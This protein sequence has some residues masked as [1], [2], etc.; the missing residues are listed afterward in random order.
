[1]NNNLSPVQRV[2]R[3]HAIMMRTPEIVSYAPAVLFGNTKLDGSI[4]TAYT[5][6]ANIT[7]S[8]HFVQTLEDPEL[9]FVIM[10]EGLHIMLRHT[11]VW[12]HLSKINHKVCNAACDYV[13]N[14]ILYDL[15]KKTDAIS[16]PKFKDGPNKNQNNALLDQ[17]FRGWTVPQVF[18][19]LLKEGDDGGDGPEGDDPEGDNPEGDGPA[20]DGGSDDSNGKGKGKLSPEREK[21][22]DQK[23]WDEHD[24]TKSDKMSED[25]IQDITKKIDQLIEEGAK[26]AGKMGA[27]N[28][29]ELASL[30]TPEFDWREALSD[31]VRSKIIKGK[32]ATTF[33]RFNRR[34]LAIDLYMPSTYDKN[35]HK[36][37]V[38]VDTSGSTTEYMTP[39]LSHVAKICEDVL[40]G[41]LILLYWDTAVAGDE[42]YTD[43]DYSTIESS[44]KPMGG[45]GTDPTCIPNYIRNNNIEDI[46]CILVLTDGVFGEQGNWSGLPEPL[47]CIAGPWMASRF[48]ATVGQSIEVK[49]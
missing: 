16:V 17:T 26:L 40:P 47:W 48:T 1:M 36:M 7:I 8:P 12:K 2:E 33:R 15:T 41:E 4:T 19:F 20:G 42:R 38:C 45:G 14:L 35:L 25:E 13:I 24:F 10:H 39:F 23:S 28:P 37:L 29:R 18:D 32:D 31:Y 22:I 5:D 46:E 43:S 34:L 49:I 30:F 9:L 3:A 11:I 44:T 27:T 6:G 21:E